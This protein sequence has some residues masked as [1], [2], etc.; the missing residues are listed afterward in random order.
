MMLDM[1]RLCLWC[2]A[3]I[4]DTKRADAIY[5]CKACQQADYGAFV[6]AEIAK[7]KVGRSCAWC[8]GPI[9]D[10]ALSRAIYC[11]KHCQRRGIYRNRIAG[12]PV[13]PCAVCGVG[14]RATIPDQKTCS[15][16]CAVE[17]RR[18]TESRPCEQCGTVMVRPLPEKKFCN[19]RCQDRWHKAARREKPLPQ[20]LPQDENQT[21]RR[22]ELGIDI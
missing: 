18:E 11:S 19:P 15:R 6:S 22:G 4:P 20:T 12:R 1:R 8:C 2:K 16:K 5:C 21:T 13:L 3:V 10:K 14:F 17:I 9:S 7:A